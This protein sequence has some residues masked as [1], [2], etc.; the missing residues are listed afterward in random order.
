MN[1]SELPLVWVEQ[2]WVVMMKDRDA[3]VRDIFTFTMKAGAEE[4]LESLVEKKLAVKEY[5][6][7]AFGSMPSTKRH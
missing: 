4:K 2:R 1:D 5:S 6:N 7:T 3:N